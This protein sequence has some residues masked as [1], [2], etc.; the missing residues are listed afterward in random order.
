M[1]ADDAGRWHAFAC[2]CS[3]PMEQSVAGRTRDALRTAK[4]Q[5][6]A[7]LIRTAIQYLGAAYTRQRGSHK[8]LNQPSRLHGHEKELRRAIPI[9]I[10]T[11]G[12]RETPPRRTFSRTAPTTGSY[13]E[14]TSGTGE[15]CLRDI[16]LKSRACG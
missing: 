9:D 14:T 15:V 4:V 3:P 1:R 2:Y 10:Y 11:S 7:I 6:I 5:K 12:S 16:A 8:A 13:Y